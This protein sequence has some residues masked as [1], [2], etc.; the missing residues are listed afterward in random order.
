MSQNFRPFTASEEVDELFKSL[1]KAQGSMSDVEAATE[2]NW[3]KYATLS[4]YLDALRE[5]L[6]KNGLSV[7]QTT[8]QT[9]NGTIELITILAHETGQWISSDMAI[10]PE[11]G[12]P[13]GVGSV[14]TYMRRYCIA[15]ITGMGSVDDDATAGT[16]SGADTLAPDQIDN[17]HWLA[18]KLFAGEADTKVTRMCHKMFSVDDVSQIPLEHYDHAVNAL[19]NQADRE[20]EA[21]AGNAKKKKGGKKADPDP[22]PEQDEAPPAEPL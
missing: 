4:Q 1:A 19:N 21:G 8:K 13:Q 3:G 7:I 14:L 17:I 20:A 6:S 10:A 9:T 2:G 16:K 15:G 18:K 5:P 11:K 12:G 22:E